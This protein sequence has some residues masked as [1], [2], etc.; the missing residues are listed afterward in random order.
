MLH[1][2]AGADPIVV[3]FATSSWPFLFAPVAVGTIC[4]VLL[5][6]GFDH[7]VTRKPYPSARCVGASIGK[8]YGDTLVLRGY[9]DTFPILLS[10]LGFGPLFRGLGSW[11]VR[12]QDDPRRRSI[13]VGGR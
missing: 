12:R 2:P 7:W 9:G 6:V 13:R 4:I 3:I 5:G 10:V 8:G 1:P 11:P